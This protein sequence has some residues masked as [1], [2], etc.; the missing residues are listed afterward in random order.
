MNNNT[1]KTILFFSI[2][3]VTAQYSFAQKNDAYQMTI[4]GV[5]VIVQASG[6]DIVEIQ[7][8]IKGGVQNYPADKAGIESL[9]M[10][11]LTECGTTKDDKNSFKNK[12]DKVSAEMSGYSDMDFASFRMNCI[13]S[14]FNT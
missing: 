13:K 8:I 14:D 3:L 11:A 5:K 4:D 1:I 6:N 10:R 7:T 12:L 2:S 9:A